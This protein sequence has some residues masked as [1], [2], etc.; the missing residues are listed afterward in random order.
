MSISHQLYI[1]MVHLVTNESLKWNSIQQYEW[2]YEIPRGSIPRLPCVRKWFPHACFYRRGLLV[3][4]SG[5]SI[6]AY[7][8]YHIYEGFLNPNNY[9][10]LNKHGGDPNPQRGIISYERFVFIRFTVVKWQKLNTA[11]LIHLIHNLNSYYKY[12]IIRPLFTIP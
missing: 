12:D 4:N 7:L 10:I 1:W 9:Y 5:L 2:H 11:H 6:K 3:L 8:I